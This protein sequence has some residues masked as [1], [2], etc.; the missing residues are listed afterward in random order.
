M[1]EKILMGHGSGG[2][3]MH[4]LVEELFAPA[5]SM[6]ALSDA[7]LVDLPPGGRTALTTDSYVVSP[8]FF[9]GG[10]IGELAVCGTVNDL[11][12]SGARP[13]YLTAGLI[14][15]EGLPLADLKRVVDSMARTAGRAGV[16]V[17]AGDTKVVEK[18]RCDGLYINT[19]GVGV[20]A[21]GVELAP[22]KIRPGDLLV[23]SAPCGT[24]GIAIMAE[25]NGLTFEP[26][27]ESDT[28]PLNSL[29]AAMIGAAP[30]LRVMR[31]PTRGGVA[32]TVREIAREASRRI[33]LREREIPVLPGVTGACA[34]LG[35]DPLYVANEGVVLAVVD[36]GDAGA[37]LEAMRAHP[38]GSSAV[39]IGTVEEEGDGKVLLET[40]AGG[41]R[42][43][44]LL[45]GEQ[46]PR[47]C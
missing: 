7:A 12:V 1:E 36:P 32:T 21:A 26:P 14:L 37:L 25:R 30:G 28:A 22:A 3:M 2:R 41:T 31:D 42:M 38:L 27:I 4:R 47:I 33:R 35:L 5:F 20:V 46:L 13:L 39:A 11:A 17:V 34:I 9:P 16:S 45:T 23:A 19:A 43:L 6:D 44:D 40:E 24:H 18:G 29:T 8:I 15:E 10:D